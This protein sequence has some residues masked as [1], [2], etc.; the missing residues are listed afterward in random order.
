MDSMTRSAP[1][2]VLRD[3]IAAQFSA[4]VALQA[5]DGAAARALSLLTDAEAALAAF[6]D[7]DAEAG[8]YRAGRLREW[9]VTGGAQ[10]SMDLPTDMVARREAK[11]GAAEHAAGMRRVHE[12]L[13]SDAVSAADA[14]ARAKDMVS[15]A[16]VA[17][18][19]HDAEKLAAELEAA[20]QTAWRIEDHLRGLV[21]L[22]VP[23]L[24]P[25]AGGRRYSTVSVSPRTAAVLGAVKPGHI[26]SQQP[27]EKQTA[28]WQSYHAALCSDADAMAG[29]VP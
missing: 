24:A 3:A 5:A 1:R 9:A 19:V 25:V 4:A 18:M 8:E 26:L 16:A 11:T 20:R 13:A 28:A 23:N 15:E 29:D 22:W 14:L 7:L 12:A 6:H 27:F 2:D 17:V 21:G 10:P